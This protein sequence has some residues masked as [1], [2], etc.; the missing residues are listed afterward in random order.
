MLS[1]KDTARILSETKM[2]DLPL[3]KRIALK[4]HLMMCKLCRRYAR[5]IATIDGAA[6]ELARRAEEAPP[7]LLGSLSPEAQERIK[8]SLRDQA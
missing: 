2:S 4:L 8:A 6:R 7:E 1:C 5:Q 3:G